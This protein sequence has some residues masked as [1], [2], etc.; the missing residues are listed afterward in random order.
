MTEVVQFSR[1]TKYLLSGLL[2]FL[3]VGAALLALSAGPWMLTLPAVLLLFWWRL[4][5]LKVVFA[6]NELVLVGLVSVR[7]FPR[8]SV[9]RVEEGAVV[10]VGKQGRERRVTIP[11]AV[12]ASTITDNSPDARVK[13]RVDAAYRRW[14]PVPAK[15]VSG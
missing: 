10:V 8:M 11:V 14:L 5:A 13:Q 9:L 15:R 6:P 1:A 12:G 4:F 7:R 3:I 2:S